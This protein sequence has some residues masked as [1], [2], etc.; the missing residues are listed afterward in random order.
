MHARSRIEVNI[1]CT[2]VRSFLYTGSRVVKEHQQS[3]VT[4]STSSIHRQRG[5][6]AF[7][8]IALKE[9]GFRRLSAFSWNSG[10][11]LGLLKPFRE[12]LAD[13]FEERAERRQSLVAGLGRIAPALFEG[14]QEPAHD[15]GMK[16]VEAKLGDLLIPSCRSKLQ[17]Q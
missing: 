5:Q 1:A 16:I 8:L 9:D 6:R 3:P 14:V 7:D 17:Q 10:N 13:V 4:Q 11:F 12:T 15:I 2:E